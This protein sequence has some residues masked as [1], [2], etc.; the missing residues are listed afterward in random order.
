MQ[1]LM[2][3]LHCL[4]CTGGKPSHCTTYLKN[5]AYTHISQMYLQLVLIVLHL[6]VIMCS[7]F[8][9]VYNQHTCMAHWVL[10]FSTSSYY[11]Y[12]IRE[13]ITT[14]PPSWSDYRAW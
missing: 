4:Q 13:L 5:N 1:K 10:E 3:L 11:I 8:C 9:N 7:R 2:S 14:K 6:H 12:L